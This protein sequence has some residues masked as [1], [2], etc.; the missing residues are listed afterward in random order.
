M[1]IISSHC[2][3]MFFFSNDILVNQTITNSTGV[4][5]WFEQVRGHWPANPPSKKYSLHT[6]HLQ[7]CDQQTIIFH[8]WLVGSV[9]GTDV[10]DIE[11]MKCC[12]R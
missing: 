3:K 8:F 6:L 7:H 9:K 1:K 2:D 5:A 4:A 10:K 12:K 11:I